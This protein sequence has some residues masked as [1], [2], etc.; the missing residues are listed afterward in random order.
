MEA[1][2]PCPNYSASVSLGPGVDREAWV[3]VAWATGFLVLMVSVFAYEYAKFDDGSFR[4]R[5]TQLD[6][7]DHDGQLATGS[8]DHHVVVLEGTTLIAVEATL[9][10]TDDVGSNDVFELE[11]EGH[12]EPYRTARS[13]SSGSISLRVEVAV[14]VEGTHAGADEHA[15]RAAAHFE[16]GWRGER[17]W[18]V[19]IRLAEAPGAQAAPGVPVELTPDG[20]NAYHLDIV[21]VTL[22]AERVA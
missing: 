20:A 5:E 21:A 14:A 1:H 22:A 6:L 4:L 16:P 17:E 19:T 15:A 9:T 2:A 3:G 13:G 8:A 12:A 18:T 11:V 7:A 10:W